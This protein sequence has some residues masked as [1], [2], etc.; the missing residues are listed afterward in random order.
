[1]TSVGLC[2]TKVMESWNG[3]TDA[4]IFQQFHEVRLI[5]PPPPKKMFFLVGNMSQFI[6][7]CQVL[8][9]T[10]IRTGLRNEWV[11]QFQLQKAKKKKEMT[12]RRAP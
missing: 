5:P 11:S 2:V 7:L 6:Q 12:D 9:L 1:M 4:F 3:E 10:L 8:I